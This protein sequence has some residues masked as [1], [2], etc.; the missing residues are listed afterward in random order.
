M[1]LYHVTTEKM[2]RRYHELGRILRPVR[3]FNTIDAALA[4]GMKTGRKVIYKVEGSPGYKLPDHHN[5]FG[6]AWWIDSD[7]PLSSI[8]CIFSA[9]NDA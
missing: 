4:W 1:T 5:Q 3:G 6:E 8:S 7:I 2:A 9:D